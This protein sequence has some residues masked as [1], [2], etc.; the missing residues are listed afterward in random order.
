M[1]G[2]LRDARRLLGRDVSI[3]GTVMKG[4]RR[5]RMLG[6]PTANLDLHHE[7]IPPSG[8]YIVK[9]KLANR[10]YRGILNIGFRL[11]F[12]EN[13]KE[14]TV[15]VHIFGFNKSIYGKDIEVIFLKRIRSERQFRNHEHLLSRIEKDV[16]IAKRYFMKV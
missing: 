10:I 6:F 9:A 8:V 1:S 5:G 12:K 4:T 14:P 11:T 13:R 15:E 7:A 16:N 3:L 2:R